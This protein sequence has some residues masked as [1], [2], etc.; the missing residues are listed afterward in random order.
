MVVSIC[1]I[2]FCYK[3]ISGI[4][5][6]FGIERIIEI[7]NTNNLF[8]KKIESNNNVLI[9]YLS[10]GLIKN[11]LELANKLREKLGDMNWKS[12]TDTE[13]LLTAFEVF[14]FEE[15]LHKIE[16][17]FAFAL[18]DKKTLN[19]ILGR[20]KLGEKPLYYGWN[21]DSF[22]FG[23]ELKALKK[24]P[25]FIQEISR[26]S[27]SLFLRY[28]YIPYPYSIYSK[29]SKLKPGALLYISLEQPKP[30]VVDYWSVSETIKESLPLR[31]SEMKEG[32]VVS[33]QI[34]TEDNMPLSVEM[35]AYVVLEIAHTEPGVKGNTAT[36]ATKPATVETGAEVN[37][38]LFINEGDKV[39]IDTET[40]NYKERVTD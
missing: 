19:L 29:T 15:T 9:S 2:I 13:T 1:R 27:L 30:K 34:N 17:M 32:E 4:G 5:I 23:S 38:P 16:G 39:K 36:N 3:N 20:D 6:S 14:G 25:S 40:G 12:S 35:P 22:L 37:V 8:P 21:G 26:K 33:I 28:S 7:L 18:W 10:N 11:S 31:K 24:H